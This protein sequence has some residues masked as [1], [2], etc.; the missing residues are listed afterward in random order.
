MNTAS[1]TKSLISVVI[2]TLIC[3]FK[4]TGCITGLN[5][6]KIIYISTRIH[7]NWVKIVVCSRDMSDGLNEKEW[8]ASVWDKMGFSVWNVW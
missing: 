6:L 7:L 5:D 8:R 3:N 1:S 2:W 4:I